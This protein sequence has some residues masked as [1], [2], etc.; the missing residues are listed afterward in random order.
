VTAEHQALEDGA[1]AALQVRGLTK[2]FAATR[3]LKGISFEVAGGEIH[4]L[5]GGNG[6]GKSTLV[7]ILAGVYRADDG[8]FVIRD[9]LLDARAITPSAVARIGLRFV[10]QQPSTF[11]EMTV[12]ENLSIGRGFETGI[13]RN[14]HWRSVRARARTVLARFGIDAEPNQ[15]LGTL[16]PAAQTMVEIAR[17][18]QDQE[19][20]KDGILVLDE[21]TASLPAHEVALLLGALRRYVAEGQTILFVTHRLDEVLAVADRVTV[22]RD[23]SH[24]ATRPRRE[25]S[26]DQLVEMIVGRFVDSVFPEPVGESDRHVVLEV[27]GLRGGAV[28]GIDLTLRSGEIVGLAGLVGSGRTSLLHMLF[29]VFPPEAGEIR[30]EGTRTVSRTPWQAMRAGIAF[31]PESR[32]DAAFVDMTLAEN[33]AAATVNSYWH[34]GFL[35]QQ[36]ERSDARQLISQF[37]IKASSPSA[38]F[39]SL[40]GGNQQ[41]AILGRWLR[42]EPRVLLLDEPTQ[43]VDV[44]ARV[45]IYAT[46]RRAAESGASVLVASSDF[47]ELAGLCDR[48]LV[49]VHG[50]VTTEVHG[51][52]LETERLQ[53]LAYGTGAA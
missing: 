6:S 22:L 40:S 28:E 13:A 24:V 18:L 48:V 41:K 49:M 4:A 15:R 23:G 16:G 1:A 25:V 2:S 17:A 5:L 7:K 44:G 51:S 12:A 19:G 31:V 46:I 8:T 30:L 50:R 27:R 32:A 38:P 3:A 52:D 43:G 10:H 21:P 14:I 47:D 42:R 35:H 20:S 34:H 45:E 36:A 53:Q 29:G 39:G 33:L 9:E 11:A 26:H 37:A